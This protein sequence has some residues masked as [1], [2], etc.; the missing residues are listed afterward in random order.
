MT[1]RVVNIY[2]LT[3]NYLNLASGKHWPSTDKINMPP[4]YFACLT[5]QHELSVSGND[6][7]ESSTDSSKLAWLKGLDWLANFMSWELISEDAGT[8]AA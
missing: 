5:P 1:R 7:I 6:V 8:L 2:D 3:A 4:A